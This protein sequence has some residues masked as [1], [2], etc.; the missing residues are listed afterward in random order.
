MSRYPILTLS[1]ESKVHDL[2]LAPVWYLLPLTSP[3]R[4]QELCLNNM[5]SLK[6]K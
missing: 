3:L 6:L 1:I 5:S 4:E 2:I